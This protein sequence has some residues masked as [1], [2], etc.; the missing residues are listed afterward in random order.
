MLNEVSF[1][2]LFIVREEYVRRLQGAFELAVLLFLLKRRFQIHS[3]KLFAEAVV[4]RWR[5][6]QREAHVAPTLAAGQNQR[7]GPRESKFEHLA[8]IDSAREKKGDF[9]IVSS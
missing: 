2:N 4:Q 5:R 3:N 9:V 7:R 6:N 8:S 1:S